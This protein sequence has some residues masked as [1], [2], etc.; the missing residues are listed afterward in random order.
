MLAQQFQDD[1][2]ARALQQVAAIGRPSDELRNAP[3]SLTTRFGEV[4]TNEQPAQVPTPEQVDERAI[5]EIAESKKPPT[6]KE[7]KRLARELNFL[8]GNNKAD[9][10][11]RQ[12]RKKEVLVGVEAPEKPTLMQ[13]V[14]FRVGKGGKRIKVITN[15]LVSA[16]ALASGDLRVPFQQPIDTLGNA[17]GGL[18]ILQQHGMR[19]RR[20]KKF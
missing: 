7:A 18:Q 9:K 10:A 19:Q 4:L 5:E 1:E 20:R 2:E 15:Q 12:I 3:R 13:V 6:R 11:G 8:P 17:T 14:T 16:Q